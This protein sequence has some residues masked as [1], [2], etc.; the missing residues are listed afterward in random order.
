M[1]PVTERIRQSLVSLHMAR[2]LETLDQTLSR[3][4]KGEISAIEAIDELL[5]EELNLRE[6]R[7]DRCW[8]AHSAPH[9]DK[10]AGKLR[11]LVPAITGPPPDHGAGPAGVHPARRGAALPWPAGNR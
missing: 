7:R 4:E 9:P 1:T 11:L 3:L 5:T 2:A 10:D 8:A 6:G